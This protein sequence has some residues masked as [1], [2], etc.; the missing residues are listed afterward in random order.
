[1]GHVYTEVLIGDPKRSRVLRS[2]MLV[3]TGATYT[4]LPPKLASDLGLPI[5]GERDVTLADGRRVKAGVGLASVEIGGREDVVEVRVFEVAEA[6]IGA[7]TLES[8]GLA[9]DPVT[10][11]LRPTR[12]FTAR[13]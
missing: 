8:L 12:S 13:A 11:E 2:R 5:L 6:V 4:C 7:F 1:M 3:D 10:G 9:V